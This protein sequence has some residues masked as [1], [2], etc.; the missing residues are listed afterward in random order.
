M[1]IKVYRDGSENT[2]LQ[3]DNNSKKIQKLTG[4]EYIQIRQ[5]YTSVKDLELGDYIIVDSKYYYLNHPPELKRK[6]NHFEHTVRFYGLQHDLAKVQFLFEEDGSFY[7]NGTLDDFMDLL[8]TNMNRVF[9]GWS[10]GTIDTTNK[11]DYHNLFFEAKNCYQVLKNLCQ[12]YNCEFSLSSKAISMSDEVG[13]DKALTFKYGENKGLKAISKKTLNNDM[14]VTRV[15]GYGSTKNLKSTYG[16]RRLVFDEGGNNYLEKNITTYGTIEKSKIFDEVFPTREG[17]VTTVNGLVNFSDTSMDFNLKSY[18]LPGVSPKIHFNTGDL[19]GYE[20]EVTAYNSTSKTFTIIKFADEYTQTLPNNTLKMHEGDKYKIID[21]DL[22]TSYVDSAES[23]L[24]VKTQ[25]YLDDNCEPGISY[26]FETDRKYFEDEEITLGI[27]DKFTIQDDDMEIDVEVRILE[28]EQSLIYPYEYKL[29]VSN[30]DQ[31]WSAFQSLYENYDTLNRIVP[32]NKL[33][34]VEK[35]LLS[36]KASAG[37]ETG[38][39][40]TTKPT[41]EGGQRIFIDQFNGTLSF[42]DPNGN[43]TLV[44]D[45]DIVGGN[46]GILLKN[47]VLLSKKNISHWLSLSDHDIAG[48]IDFEDADNGVILQGTH[49]TLSTLGKYK[50]LFRAEGEIDH[51]NNNNNIVGY[52]GTAEIKNG[53][54]KAYSG[55]FH[56]GNFHVDLN[57]NETAEFGLYNSSDF[58]RIDEYGK[59]TFHGDAR[60]KHEIPLPLQKWTNQAGA[61]TAATLQYEGNH[62][63]YRFTNG[64]DEEIETIM[65]LPENLATG[66]NLETEVNWYA[67]TTAAVVRWTLNY[68]SQK[69]DE[70]LFGAAYN[71]I[72]SLA[73]VSAIGSGLVK[74][75][76]SIPAADISADDNILS[77]VLKRKG[78]HAGDTL[79]SDV[80]FIGAKMKIVANKLGEAI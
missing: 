67:A 29:K 26:Q 77:L 49:N 61:N 39:T 37:E 31:E 33:Q 52:Y 41:I 55:Y 16:N 60:Y 56:L 74:T 48:V 63:S 20:F 40:I 24:K 38:R 4:D 51:A 57:L 17:S 54:G 21:I 69:E 62:V 32:L 27:G 28:L 7:L 75:V 3:V 10:K 5:T 19:A 34:S 30:K 23:L 2:T 58:L 25:R 47:G 44:L 15:Y 71:S 65:N 22:P 43:T 59:L 76:L 72:S 1:K 73:S 64:V 18:L 70:V 53:T 12:V 66:Q 13:T 80:R 11:D 46:P 79:G 35:M 14:V 36:W 50:C 45:D 6:G 78:T 8:V 9:A 42:Y 68:L